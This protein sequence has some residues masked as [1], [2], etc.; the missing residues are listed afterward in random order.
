MAGRKELFKS[1]G[2]GNN[3]HLCESCSSSLGEAGIPDYTPNFCYLFV[4]QRRCRTLSLYSSF[5]WLYESN[6]IEEIWKEVVVA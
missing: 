3:L 4:A 1:Y 5:D 2:C 6:D